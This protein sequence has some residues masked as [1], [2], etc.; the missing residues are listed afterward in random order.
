MNKKLL[1]EISMP[2]MQMTL[3]Y[4]EIY[5]SGLDRTARFPVDRYAKIAKKIREEDKEALI[6][7]KVPRLA[8]RE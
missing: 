1:N 5:S 4:D 6:E 7:L 2:N 8:K 3:Y